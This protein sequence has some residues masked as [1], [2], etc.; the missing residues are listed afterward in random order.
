MCQAGRQNFT[1]DGRLH[2]NLR[3]IFWEYNYGSRIIRRQNTG[4]KM[5]RCG[6]PRQATG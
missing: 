2:F 3:L 5:V 6:C 1:G 4:G